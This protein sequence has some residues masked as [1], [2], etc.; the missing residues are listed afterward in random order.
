MSLNLT[1]ANQDEFTGT[2]TRVEHI[3]REAQLG[4][5]VEKFRDN[6]KDQYYPNW[7][8]DQIKESPDD[9][10]ILVEKYKDEQMA[11]M[12]LYFHVQVDTD[13]FM[14]WMVVPTRRG[15]SMS[16]L[17]KVVDKN[18]LPLLAI[19][20]DLPKW[21]GVPIQCELNKDNYYR[22]SK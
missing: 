9:E 16:N 7:L 1:E 5:R 3:S 6:M 2:I 4:D 12:G 22:I 14:E 19:P 8:K 13:E 21:I 17:K 11:K 10:E 15:Y 18:K 20:E